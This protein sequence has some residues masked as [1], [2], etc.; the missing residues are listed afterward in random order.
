MT[1]NKTVLRRGDIILA[2][3]GPAVGSE[4]DKTR[5]CLIVSPEEMNRHAPTVVIAPLTTKFKPYPWRVDCTID[6]EDGQ[7]M[8]DQIRTISKQRIVKWLGIM[9]EETSLRA[10]DRLSEIFAP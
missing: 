9:P 4:V 2:P 5:P 7:I 3:L 1:V 6:G 8:L 10:L